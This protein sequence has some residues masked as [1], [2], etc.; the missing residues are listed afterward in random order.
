MCLKVEVLTTER[1]SL[2]GSSGL[3]LDD[4]EHAE[5]TAS[6]DAS[7]ELDDPHEVPFYELEIGPSGD[8]I[9]DTP[10]LVSVATLS[11]ATDAVDETP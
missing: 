3:D 7:E 5:H 6:V 1:T 9:H 11:S 4:H 10:V 8:L 2:E